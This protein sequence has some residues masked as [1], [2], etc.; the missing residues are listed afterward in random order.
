MPDLKDFS[1]V[2]GEPKDEGKKE[3]KPDNGKPSPP[4]AT[5]RVPVR[6]SGIFKAVEVPKVLRDAKEF[7]PRLDVNINQKNRDHIRVRIYE[8]IVVAYKFLRRTDGAA[9]S[10]VAKG[11]VLDISEGGL[12][13]EGEVPGEVQSAQLKE[14]DIL[15]GMNVFLPYVDGR[16]KVLGQATW[17]KGGEAENTKRMGVRFIEMDDAAK[18]VLKAYFISSQMPGRKKKA[19][20]PD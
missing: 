14:G 16:M 4:P 18:S 8:D 3:K 11:K 20:E 17:L 1:F 5:A 7:K 15:V 13:F 10:G 2:G 9:V 19:P 12:Q 6:P